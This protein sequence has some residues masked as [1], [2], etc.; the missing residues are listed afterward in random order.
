MTAAA[1]RCRR[2]F[3]RFFPN[4]FTD[5]TYLEWERNYKA[6]AHDRWRAELNRVTFRALLEADDVG[7]IMTRV[8]RIESRTNLLFSFEKMALR[9]A[10]RGADGAHAMA[11]GLD[12][13]LHGGGRL[14]QRFERWCDTVASL[15]RRQTRVLTWPIVTVF[16]F[17]AQPDRHIF[18]KPNVT[19]VAAAQYG[20]ELPYQ[21]KPN[22]R[23]YATLLE[24]ADRVHTDLHDLQP[25]DMIDVQSF[26]WVQ[27]SDEYRGRSF[28]AA[29]TTSLRR[30]S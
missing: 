1:Q 22:W 28:Q 19:R 20:F 3:L 7:E 24:L 9:D 16:P 25:R 10:V 21:P 6:H 26:L 11:R 29:R 2:R 4:G 13:L 14:H 17:L 23:T 15:P 18:L 8:I 12:D 5:D 30:A 27:G